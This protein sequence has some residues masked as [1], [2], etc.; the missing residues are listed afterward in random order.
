MK[1]KSLGFF[2][3]RF[4]LVVSIVRH[5]TRVLCDVFVCPVIGNEFCAGTRDIKCTSLECT[6]QCIYVDGLS[7]LE[8]HGNFTCMHNTSYPFATCDVDCIG[9]SA[10]VNLPIYTQRPLNFNTSFKPTADTSLTAAKVTITIDIPYITGMFIFVHFA[11][12]REKNISYDPVLVVAKMR[13]KKEIFTQMHTY[14]LYIHIRRYITKP[15]G[16]HDRSSM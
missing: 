1:R 12:M 14:I 10:C 4:L 9:S 13:Q 2:I 7:C 6:L 5:S 16:L 3:A 8:D 11:K 15:F